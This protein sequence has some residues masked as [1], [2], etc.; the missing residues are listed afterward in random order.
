MPTLKE[1]VIAQ[2]GK[3]PGLT[4]REIADRILGLGAA[5]Q[6]VNQ[7]ARALAKSG[8]IDRCARADGKLGNYPGSHA[9]PPVHELTITAS[10]TSQDASQC[11]LSEDDVKRK[12]QAWLEEDGWQ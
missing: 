5:Q 12:L 10:T 3:L 8:R 11:T 6:S 7:A 2:V 9:Y 4:D 1:R